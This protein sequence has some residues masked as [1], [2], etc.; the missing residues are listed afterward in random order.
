M[1]ER[2]ES[3]SVVAIVALVLVVVVAS[4]FLLARTLPDGPPPDTFIIGDS[5]T[6]LSAGR[7]QQQFDPNHLQ[8]VAKPGF[9]SADLLPL[10][11]KA[12]GMPD[13]PAQ[14]REHVGVLVGYNDVR[15]KDVSPPSLHEMVDATAQF[16]CGIWLTIPVRPYG[17]DNPNVMATSDLAAEWNLRMEHEVAQHP[18]LHI[19]HDWA[20]AVTR[21]KPGQLL[22]DDNVH[23][24]E[25]GQVRLAAIYRSAMD[26]YC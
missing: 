8:F 2:A 9:T 21:S 1:A 14:A 10:V 23:P 12:M 26:H 7:L 22:K 15:V 6:F 13:G 5:V 25:V 16:K 24:N 4:T 17:K 19:V 3:S 20:D 11:I 18:N